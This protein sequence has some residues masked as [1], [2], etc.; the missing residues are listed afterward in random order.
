MLNTSYTKP[1]MQITYQTLLNI[2]RSLGLFCCC[3][4]FCFRNDRLHSDNLFFIRRQCPSF[5]KFG[6][7][8]IC[9]VLL[10]NCWLLQNGRMY[11]RSSEVLCMVLRN[12]VY[13]STSQWYCVVENEMYKTIVLFCIFIK[14][15]L[16]FFWHIIVSTELFLNLII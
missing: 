2:K 11:D 6:P 16:H 13:V 4:V 1:L 14:M 7:Y 8:H 5:C 12:G 9:N 10:A 15:F 3:Y